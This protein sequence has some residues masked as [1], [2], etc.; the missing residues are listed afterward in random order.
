MR[1]PDAADGEENEERRRRIRH[2]RARSFARRPI[3]FQAEPGGAMQNQHRHGHQTGQQRER[4]EQR[5]QR[6]VE[7]AAA[8]R[9]RSRTARPRTDCRKRRRR[10]APARSRRRTAPSP[11]SCASVGSA[12][13]L[14]N[15]KPTGRRI[16]AS[17]HQEHR[18]IEARKASRIER[19]PSRENRAAAQDQPDLIALPHRAD[20]VDRRPGARYR[21][22]PTKGSRMRRAEIEAVHDRKPDQQNAEQR[23]PDDAQHF[24]IA[25]WSTPPRMRASGSARLGRACRPDP[26]GCI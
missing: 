5:K 8:G 12:S 21:C 25:S 13:L 16:S 18:Q 22:A 17:Q 26:A 14:R 15:L 10:P 19:R 11:K 2:D 20:G 1:D 24:V 4:V 7:S 9:C 23:P 6:D 3:G